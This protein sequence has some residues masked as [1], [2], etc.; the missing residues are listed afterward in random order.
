LPDAVEKG[1]IG[2]FANND[3]KNIRPG[4]KRVENDTTSSCDSWVAG[5]NTITSVLRMRSE[6]RS[7]T[8][9][10]VF[11]PVARVAGVMIAGT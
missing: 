6:S 8:M 10:R 11:H 9:K 2:L 4:D 7:I 3:D 5:I 1:K